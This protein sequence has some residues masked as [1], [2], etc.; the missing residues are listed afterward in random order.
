MVFHGRGLFSLKE[1]MMGMPPSSFDKTSFFPTPPNF[2]LCSSSREKG[3]SMIEK[4]FSSSIKNKKKSSFSFDRA[5][6]FPT[7]PNFLLCSSSR[8]KGFCSLKEKFFAP[9]P[10]LT[11]IAIHSLLPP[12]SNIYSMFLAALFCIR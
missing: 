5:S 8:V 3:F 7:V 2:L 1:E 12:I 4:G 9:H 6:F 10:Y 11:L